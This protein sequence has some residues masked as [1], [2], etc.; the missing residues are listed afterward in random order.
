MKTMTLKASIVPFDNL[1]SFEDITLPS[2]LSRTLSP[3]TNS[4]K[5]PASLDV[6]FFVS[7]STPLIEGSNVF[8]IFSKS[9]LEIVVFPL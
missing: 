3:L 9:S 7:V 4:T 8:K 5:Y 6:D 2:E 1:S